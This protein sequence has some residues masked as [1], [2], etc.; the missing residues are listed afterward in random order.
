MKKRLR[1]KLPYTVC[2]IIALV[3]ASIFTVRL[4]DWQLIHGKEYKRLATRSTSFNSDSTP[5]RGEILDC[6]GE[7]LVTNTTHYKIVFDKL[8][9]N[10]KKL[11]TTVLDLVSLLQKTGDKWDNVLPVSFKDGAYSFTKNS[12]EDVASLKEFLKAGKDAD[13]ARC[14][15]QLYTRYSLGGDFSDEQKLIL[16]SVHYNMELCGYSNSTPYTFA[17][18]VSRDAV[19]AVSENTQGVAGVDVQTYLV[20]AAQ[21][22]TLA[23][24]VLGALGA[25]SQ[26]EYEEFGSNGK[27]YAITD[28]VG[29]FGIERA[30]ETDL[31]GVGGTKIIQ[32]NSDGT[33][34]NTI[35]TIDSRPGNTVWLTLDS[36]LQQVAVQSLETNV[37]AAQAEG[38]SECEYTG[39]KLQGEDCESGAVVM[40]DV[41]D[42]SVLAA[43]SYPTY[44]LNKYSEYGDYYTSL[45]SD[46]HSP[47]YNRA[48]SGTF[49]WGSV[50]KPC[51]AL[52]ALEEKIITPDTKIFCTQKYDYYPSNVVECMHR[53]EELDLRGALTRSCNYYF[54]ETGRRMGIDTMY[55]YAER[56]GLGE[57]T[58]LEVEESK[59]T[60]A[61]RDSTSWMPGNTVQAAIGQSD[62]AFTPVQLATYAATIANNGIRLKTHIISKI[63]DYER[64]TVIADYS[65]PE[66]AD[67]CGISAENMKTVQGDMLNVTQSE[68]GTAYSVFGKYKIKV[69][70]KTGTA[71]NAGSD[72]TTFICYAP[73]DKP[74]VAVAVVLE[75]G[76]KGK[77]SMQVAKDLLDAYF[78]APAKKQTQG[79]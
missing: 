49:E 35:E 7:G 57:Y 18:D 58:G 5:T 66:Q 70:A 60:L 42:F 55:L 19:S 73:F 63:T 16:A 51:V 8:Y 20:R 2:I 6:N 39:K 71:E 48:F 41:R 62:N 50:F 17:S 27:H 65:A 45:A 46:K 11:D 15:Q 28:D 33:I 44:D 75:H 14:A 12:D 13:A 72:H 3:A 24:H 77:Y 76:V 56:F 22:P 21:N 10:G 26:E 23:P 37:K 31:K 40:L 69:A 52:A 34:V 54:A 29:K 4:A 68:D 43:A 78:D 61:G 25:V 32:R 1:G 36:K 47:M 79:S 67:N 9:I 38:K 53:H 64:Q 30:C 59:G 74:Q